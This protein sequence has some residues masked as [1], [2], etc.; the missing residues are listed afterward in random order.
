MPSARMVFTTG[1]CTSNN[2]DRC[3]WVIRT[4]PAADEWHVCACPHH[5]NGHSQDEYRQAVYVRIAARRVA[6][7]KSDRRQAVRNTP[8][9][10]PKAPR[11]CK[12]GCDQQ[13]KGGVYCPGHDSKHKSR[14][15]AQA[16][17]GNALALATLKELGWL[18]PPT[19]PNQPDTH[20]QPDTIVPQEPPH[21]EQPPPR[22]PD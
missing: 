3:P 6:I 14:L 10:A 4:N 2:H 20:S 18:D 19:E 22:P 16:R 21:G 15:R 9:H 11:Q 12:C 8:T 13:T 17:S 1:H 7:E 5:R